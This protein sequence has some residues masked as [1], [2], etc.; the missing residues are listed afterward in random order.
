MS[1]R[2]DFLKQAALLTGVA[3]F[4]GIVPQSIEKAFAID[5][6]P[7]TSYTDAEH[8]VILMQENR[9]FDHELGT[10]E[11]V[12]G[13]N[14]PRAV[15]L[16]NGNSVFLQTSAA[17]GE[18]YAPWR[19]NIKDTR[20]TW[21]GSIPHSRSS[22]V[23]AW[24]GGNYNNWIDAKRP[25]RPEY[26]QVPLT[27]GH[28]TREDLP[29][30]YALADAFTVCDQNYCGV[31]SSTTPNRVVFWTGT[32]R[33]RQ[34]PD[35]LV[36]LNN[37]RIGA[38]D[39]IW[40]TYPEKLE[41][42]GVSWKFYQNDLDN[43]GGMT[44]EQRVWLGNFGLNVLECFRSYHV[45]LT[46]RFKEKMHEEI[47][48][49]LEQLAQLNGKLSQQGS[50]SHGARLVRDEIEVEE[51]RLAI[52]R[53]KLRLSDACLADLPAR[54]QQLNRRAFVTNQADPEFHALE[55]LD[56]MDDRTMRKM[57]V[58]KGDVLYQFRKDVESGKLPA[59]SWLAA[60]ENFS[61]HP[62]S[63]WYGAWYV[64]E[65]MDILTR[66]PEI[67]KKTI[68]ILTYDENDGYFDH[69][70]SFAAPDS[71]NAASGAASKGIGYR[72]LEY[73]YASDEI[74]Q[75][76][77]PSEARSG[78]I[79]LGFRVPMIIA[80]PWSRGG[81]VNSQ[82]FDH[83]STIQFLE[84]FVARKFG[85]RTT[86]T[87]ISPW[88]R[89]VCGDL[90]SA[91]RT[92]DG[93]KPKLPFIERN[94]FVESIQ[95]AEFKEIPSNY[96]AMTANEIAEFN[97]NSQPLAGVQEPGIR[98][99]CAIPYELYVDGGLNAGG[100]AFEIEMRAANVLFRGS[101]AGAP[102]NVYL[103]GTTMGSATT[104]RNISV[105]GMAVATYAV[106]AGDSLKTSI[107]LSRFA[108]GKY[109]IAVHGPNGFYRAFKGGG[110]PG[111]KIWCS[112][113]LGET[114]GREAATGLML[115][116]SHNGGSSRYEVKITDHYAGKSTTRRISPEGRQEVVI[117]DL[118]RQHRWYDVT[119]SV[120]GM[121][122]FQR[123]Y[124][125]RVETGASSFTDPQ[126]G[127]VWKSS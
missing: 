113:K 12:R 70:P 5:P 23:D 79:G 42:A 69:C 105:P 85:K 22:Q 47:A 68:F 51:M 41:D 13:F 67:W 6:D 32:V 90:T 77:S 88:R 102:F 71:R 28:Y 37:G 7:G 29:F 17:G 89:A 4:S 104:A 93:K 86:E 126:M 87:N 100:S 34:S 60:P 95:R 19:L 118:V 107:A 64:S 80:S 36:F 21:L 72:G 103:Y 14:D 106:K 44:E 94:P 58:P 84:Q 40:G 117:L 15:R 81:W 125:G 123:R 39:M 73:A 66:N 115:H 57:Q 26:R 109:D 20:A 121:K 92:Y 99:A 76:I 122:G 119:I 10:L 54:T 56:F 25:Y 62:V 65:A 78:P 46:P 120:N 101:A 33:D 16:G 3:G 111:I 52:L 8:I 43:S 114:A 83:S 108:N 1:S 27:M 82:V 110:D 74:R 9:S 97:R 75:G 49:T 53:E 116:L 35:S 61:D 50:G 45:E 2:R 30:Y 91:F 59:V 124:A 96:K 63:P 18:T 55:T 127:R 24:N 11:G 38:G 98:P 112:Y 48:A 31:M